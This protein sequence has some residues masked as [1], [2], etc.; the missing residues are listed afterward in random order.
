MRQKEMIV[1]AVASVQFI[2]NPALQAEWNA[3]PE[4]EVMMLGIGARVK[5]AAQ[6]NAPVDTGA[7]RASIYYDTGESDYGNAMVVIGT[8]IRY[9]GF[10]EYGTYK[11][12]AQPYLRPALDEVI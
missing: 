11:M 2:P 5:T 7:L 8:T 6:A 9:G 3:S 12:A 10:V 4:A 1:V